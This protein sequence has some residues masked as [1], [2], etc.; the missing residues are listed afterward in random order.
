MTLSIDE[1]II[2]LEKTI[3]NL[4]ASTVS[5]AR[6]AVSISPNE[7]I[8]GNG[9][10]KLTQYGLEV[11]PGTSAAA[12][13]VY[14]WDD[15][16][17]YPSYLVNYSVGG[18]PRLGVGASNA[19]LLLLTDTGFDLLAYINTT[20]YWALDGGTASAYA[21]QRLV[22]GGAATDSVGMLEVRPQ[23]ATDVGLYLKAAASQSGNLIKL[24]SS[25]SAGLFTVLASGKL[26]IGTA[27]P[28]AYADATLEGGVLCIKDTTTPTADAGYGKI[29]GKSDNYLYYQ[30]SAGGEYALA[31][32]GNLSA[33]IPKALLTE[34]GDVIY[35]SGVATPA[36]LVHGTAGQVLQSG[37]HAANPAWANSASGGT[38]TG[39]N[40][41]NR[42]I[43]HGLGVVPKAV[44]LM[45]TDGTLFFHEIRP[46]VIVALSATVTAA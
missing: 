5:G 17:T 26:G 20:L 18:V 44:F 11:Y 33:L 35:A 29:Y 1:R 32:Y 21:S 25:A 10:T 4:G 22:V 6:G 43:P 45:I 41:A 9:A 36:A 15:T 3:T 12:H 7:I 16:L 8:A 34:Q 23:A 28:S 37:G 42:A 39:N 30:N 38:Y 19:H 24:V 13:G 2:R 46:D 31:Y 40:T 27:S 14:L